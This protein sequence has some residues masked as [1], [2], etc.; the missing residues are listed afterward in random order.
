MGKKD[1]PFGSSDR[2]STDPFGRPIAEG[3]DAFSSTADSADAFGSSAQRADSAEAFGSPAQRA[4]SA[5]AF[6]SPARRADRFG[7]SGSSELAGS[8]PARDSAQQPPAG[9]AQSAAP[10]APAD[11][12]WR[13]APPPPSGDPFRTAPPP[14]SD[15]PAQ[16]GARRVADTA[17]PA[18]VLGIFGLF[19]W[20]LSPFAWGLALKAER[21]IGASGETLG[22]RGAATAGKVLGI[23]GT[24]LLILTILLIALG[25]V[26]GMSI[27]SGPTTTTTIAPR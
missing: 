22:G 3:D 18:L 27:E 4:D 9:K 15:A 8:P 13:A 11:D 6:G 2:P 17:I 14:G 12:P 10:H 25:V 20:I 26:F 23:I 1:N 21:E 16:P 5:D 19:C 24:V 7:S